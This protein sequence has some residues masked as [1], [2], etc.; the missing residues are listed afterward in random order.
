MGVAC[1]WPPCT[2]VMQTQKAEVAKSHS[3]A[4]E[5]PKQS[6]K[7]RSAHTELSA[8]Q[9]ERNHSLICNG[10]TTKRLCLRLCFCYDSCWAI[11]VAQCTAVGFVV[12]WL[13]FFLF[14]KTC[15]NCSAFGK[16]KVQQ[17]WPRHA[18]CSNKAGY[19][20]Q[21]AAYMGSLLSSLKRTSK[22]TAI[23]ERWGRSR[24]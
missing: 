16:F 5:S 10:R 23:K 12:G 17:K 4:G 14:C 19:S 24:V 2:H 22:G 3:S 9:P 21:S 7:H 13:G 6:S 20:L 11:Q 1:T 15:L 18:N 8:A